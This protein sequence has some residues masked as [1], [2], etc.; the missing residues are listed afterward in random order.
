[1][2]PV[3]PLA[4]LLALLAAGCRGGAPERL[5][6]PAAIADRVAERARADFEGVRDFTVTGD[7]LTI[8]FRRTGPDSLVGFEYRSF[9]DV[10]A[11][12]SLGR[13]APSPYVP[14]N[15]VQLARGL[16]A[17][18]RLNGVVSEGDEA[19]YVLDALD[20]DAFAGVEAG[21]GPDSIR[22][23]VDAETF[24]IRGV[25]IV[26]PQA[27]LDPAAA[28]DAPP[29]VE[30]RLYSDFRTAD[31]LTLPFQAS[32]IVEGVV[33]TP[34]QRM[35]QGGA[36]GAQRRQAEGLPQG[37]REAALRAIDRQIRFLETGVLEEAFTVEAVR[38]NAGVPEAAFAPRPPG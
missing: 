20:P 31:G 11:G 2:R 5:S 19:I 22:V 33:V 24:R 14:P 35:L 12:D 26:T 25:R 21:T 1:M 36:L 37:R 18:A 8:Y 7:G 23:L 32:I 28:P 3:L 15:A 13:P 6:D 27:A 34:E 29:V 4:A 30:R 10:G 38:V 17:H 16:R 9:S